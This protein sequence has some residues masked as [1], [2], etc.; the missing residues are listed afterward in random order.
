MWFWRGST[1]A[2]HL[3]RVSWGRGPGLPAS[4]LK[5]VEHR[6]GPYHQSRSRSP[7]H[8]GFRR[9]GQQVG[10]DRLEVRWHLVL[11]GYSASLSFPRRLLFGRSLLSALQLLL[12]LGQILFPLL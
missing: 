2:S 12:P 7:M 5:V 3:R 11:L 4:S 9:R 6:V 8:R 10:R 1:T